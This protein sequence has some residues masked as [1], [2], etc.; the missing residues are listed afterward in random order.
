MIQKFTSEGK[1]SSSVLHLSFPEFLNLG[2]LKL[3]QYIHDLQAFQDFSPA[4][5][6]IVLISYLFMYPG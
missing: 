2:L 4:F 3:S 1:I 5:S 6:I